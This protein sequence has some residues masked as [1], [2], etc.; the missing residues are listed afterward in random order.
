MR[1]WRCSK[2]TLVDTGTTKTAV[3][4]DLVNDLPEGPYRELREFQLIDDGGNVRGTFQVQ[5]WSVD[6]DLAVCV[7]AVIDGA[8]KEL[9]LIQHYG[10]EWTTRQKE[11]VVLDGLEPAPER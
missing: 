2:G 3:L 4:S 9:T 8:L 11:Q 6:D 5:V 7:H 10:R 1:A